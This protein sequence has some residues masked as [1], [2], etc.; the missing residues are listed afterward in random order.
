MLF[1]DF[2]SK[3]NE[4]YMLKVSKLYWN[5]KSHLVDTRSRCKSL[6]H[7]KLEKKKRLPWEPVVC[8]HFES[9]TGTYNH[10][11]QCSVHQHRDGINF[12]EN[13]ENRMDFVFLN[14]SKIKN[15]SKLK[16]RKQR[17]SWS[18]ESMNSNST[19]PI[20]RW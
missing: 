16:K 2:F 14:G 7:S 6:E 11:I 15:G 8:T 20:R 12:V 18:P 17:L 3:F 19:G 13:L 10:S 1:I 9:S 5:L 4:Q